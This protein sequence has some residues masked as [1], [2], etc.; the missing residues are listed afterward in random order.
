MV[1]GAIS[2]SV[3]W[4]FN[5]KNKLNIRL[6]DSSIVK[7]CTYGRCNGEDLKDAAAALMISEFMNESIFSIYKN[8]TD[9]DSNIY[10][11]KSRVPWE[12]FKKIVV[13]SPFL[14]LLPIMKYFEL[15]MISNIIKC[16]K[17]YN[18]SNIDKCEKLIKNDIEFDWNIC[19]NDISFKK[20][21]YD[22]ELKKKK[23]KKN[24]YECTEID[25]SITMLRRL[26]G[27]LTSNRLQPE[28]EFGRISALRNVVKDQLNSL[29]SFFKKNI[30]NEAEE[31]IYGSYGSYNKFISINEMLIQE[32]AQ[33]MITSLFTSHGID[34]IN[35]IFLGGSSTYASILNEDIIYK[36]LNNNDDMSVIS[37]T[38]IDISKIFE[39]EPYHLQLR[40]EE[41]EQLYPF[42]Y[43]NFYKGKYHNIN[44]FEY[45]INLKNKK[46]DKEYI[47][48]DR[49]II[50]REFLNG[51]K[52]RL[53][54]SLFPQNTNI[55]KQSNLI[56]E[57]A[58]ELGFWMI[59]LGRRLD[60]IGSAPR[61]GDM[62]TGGLNHRCADLWLEH[63]IAQI[64]R[65]LEY[66]SLCNFHY[67]TRLSEEVS[68]D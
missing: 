4:S 29:E 33:S 25:E 65:H 48:N 31:D 20:F 26:V 63:Q 51:R 2:D 67:K 34:N 14:T 68:V 18:Y 8:D 39:W 15:P 1:H 38:V 36:L 10:L 13:E 7:I 45:D 11:E 59:L 47:E 41:S 56:E 21:Y 23:N 61:M 60:L 46:N 12:L 35:N 27:D 43:D 22:D 5:K 55:P 32:K 3:Y 58:I 40:F 42:L 64:R 30:S 9:E 19:E 53:S 28:E 52:K 44:L 57:G 50:N 62:H 6:I 66:I 37:N 49:L 16:S 24:E 54:S 17:K